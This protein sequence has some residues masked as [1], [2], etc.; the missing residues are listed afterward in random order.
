MSYARSIRVKYEEGTYC[1]AFNRCCLK[2]VS[3]IQSQQEGRAIG[4]VGAGYQ[5]SWSSA[6]FLL[7]ALR[8]VFVSGAGH[9][10]AV[11]AGGVASMYGVYGMCGMMSSW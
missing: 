3:A 6:L 7:A 2:A 1:Q 9:G 5:T 8:A 4:I 10:E 11:V